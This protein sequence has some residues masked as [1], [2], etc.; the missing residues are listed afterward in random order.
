MA[1]LTGFLH[2][3]VVGASVFR[4]LVGLAPI[5]APD[6]AAA[7]F[8]F[9]AEHLNATARFFG[10]LFG[11][12]DIAV[13]VLTLWA[14]DKAE[15]VGFILIFNACVDG[16]DLAACGLAFMGREKINRAAS[17]SAVVAAIFTLLWVWVWSQLR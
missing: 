9:P 7:L 11:I 5:V 13:G 10:R 14:V 17:G 4:M 16:G 15:I 1:G 3:I 6:Q 8:K 2:H 12:R